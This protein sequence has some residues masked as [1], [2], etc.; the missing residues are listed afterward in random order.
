M[1]DSGMT[2]ELAK[3]QRK[4]Y[5]DLLEFY[6]RMNRRREEA[7]RQFICDHEY[8]AWMGITPQ[9]CKKCGKLAKPMEVRC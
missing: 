9:P 7:L 2:F 4:H 5:E 8:D 6:D 1:D 3:M